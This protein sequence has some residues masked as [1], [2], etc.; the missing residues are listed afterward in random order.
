[1]I[2]IVSEDETL[3][4]TL[5]IHLRSLEDF[6]T[7]P[8]EI[9]H[10]R[11]S[12][13][14]SLVVIPASDAQGEEFVGLERVLGF[15][16]HIPQARRAPAPV[17]YIESAARRP[18][19]TLV[20]SLV[21]D[22]PFASLPWP[23]DPQELL[24]LAERSLERPASPAGLRERARREWVAE[25]VEQ[26][27]AGIDLPPLRQAIDPRNAAWPVLLVGEIGTRRGLL[28][29]YL[30]NLAEPPR[31]ELI[32]LPAT[33]LAPSSVEEQVLARAA[34]RRVTVFLQ[35]VDAPP[36]EV[37]TELGQLLSESGALGIEPIRWIASA[38][39][40]G[41]LAPSLRSLAWLRVDLPALRERPDRDELIWSL[42]ESCGARIRREVSL[43]PAAHEELAR[44]AWPGNLRELES[45]LSTSL[46][47]ARGNQLCV[48]DLTFNPP[49]AVA[50]LEMEAPG[51]P[52]PAGAEEAIEAPSQPD[53]PSS[54]DALDREDEPESRV[55]EHPAPAAGSP[56][57]TELPDLGD[58]LPPIAQ[59]LRQPLMA[60]RTYASLLEQRPDD[61]EV[62]R[63]LASIV[64][65]DLAAVEVLLQQ[66]ERFTGF[67]PPRCDAVDLVAV[68][69]DELARMQQVVQKR[70]LVVLRE[71]DHEAP[72]ALADEEQLR[73]ALG[74]LLDCAVRMAPDG[75][76]LYIAS[77]HR[78]AQGDE[79][80]GHRLMI[81]FHS[82]EDVL[83]GPEDIPGPAAPVEV[84][85]ARALIARMQGEFAVDTAGSQDNL[86]LIELPAPH[87]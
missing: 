37:Q 80:A 30:H 27:Y 1:M 45:V 53:Q 55:D 28:A 81:R 6:R 23:P 44:Y 33:S 74:G 46:A 70:G 15:L 39:R 32:V 77:R 21:D 13:T 69:A 34:G 43:D 16:R 78:P 18:S 41:G 54:A 4:R 22:R 12:G 56:S 68:V 10:W 25:A 35:D 66:L 79:A 24:E 2:W 26:L 31:Q 76:D 83:V 20:A 47:G 63:E 87:G 67:P 19:A 61:A 57:E 50:P 65:G 14:P 38:T 58:M 36:R 60:V 48:E 7:G 29:R 82:P 62:R 42:L 71:L 73:F 86:I 84:V 49:E 52:E 17:I 64:D 85:M 75:G 72:P 5:A 40:P 8:A 51:G 59:R 3:T 9:G 11:E